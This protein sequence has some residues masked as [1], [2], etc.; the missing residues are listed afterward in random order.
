[1]KTLS[2][3]LQEDPPQARATPSDYRL[4]QAIYAGGGVRN[5]AYSPFQV[6]AKVKPAGGQT[7]TVIMTATEK[8]LTCGCT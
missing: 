4:G 1:M 2:E 3:L 5:I 6:H 7:R 8:G